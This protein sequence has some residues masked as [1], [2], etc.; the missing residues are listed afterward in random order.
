MKI[1]LSGIINDSLIDGEGLR[2]VIFAQG[3]RHNCY[4]C[5][6]KHTHDFNGGEEFDTEDVINSISSDYISEGITFSGGD[7]FEQAE[8]FYNIAK[9]IDK[10]IWCYT[11]YTIEY[12]IENCN[13]NPYW[14]ELL[15]SIDTLVDGKFDINK[16]DKKLK[17]RGSSNQRI[18]NVKEYLK[19]NKVSL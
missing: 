13:N 3:C 17:Y 15:L 2:T 10:N 14:K 11:G 8:A 6:N 9:N 7:P 16:K 5:F 12:I 4:G 1:R 18:I 19:D